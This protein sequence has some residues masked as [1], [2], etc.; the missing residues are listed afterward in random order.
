[1]KRTSALIA[2]LALL[3]CAAVCGERGGPDGNPPPDAER[4]K[5]KEVLQRK[6]TFEFVETPLQEAI[7]FIN[8]LTKTN[9]VLDQRIANKDTKITLRV[10]DMTLELALSWIVKLAD[11]EWEIRDQA[12]YVFD[13]KQER[14]GDAEARQ[15]ARRGAEA[16]PAER[17]AGREGQMQIMPKLSVKLTDGTVIEADM[18]L[19]LTIPGLR[20]QILDR[21]FDPAAEGLLSCQLGRDIVPDDPAHLEKIK[22]LLTHTVPGVKIALDPDL[23]VLVVTADKP[24]DLRR[25]AA[26]LRAFRPEPPPMHF[27]PREDPDFVVKRRPQQQPENQP[28]KPPEREAP[29]QF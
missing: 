19:L 16:R 10:T 28:P 9:T 23:R 8:G 12:I 26:L 3:S 20:Q 13:P 7:N 5:I 6:V 18:P 24:E 27:G 1:M 22:G 25:A 15:A 14:R 29:G 21:T 2:A 4:Q 11:L 17:Q